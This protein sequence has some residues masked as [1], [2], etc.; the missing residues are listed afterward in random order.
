MAIRSKYALHPKNPR[1]KRNKKTKRKIELQE[2]ENPK[3]GE[4]N[5]VMIFDSRNFR[6]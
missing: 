5:N 6:G 4:T 1:R 3:R 2:I